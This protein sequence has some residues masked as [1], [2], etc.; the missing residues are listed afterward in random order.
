MGLDENMRSVFLL[1]VDISDRIKKKNRFVSNC[2]AKFQRNKKFFACPFSLFF[3]PNDEEKVL[4]ERKPRFSQREKKRN[5]FER[6]TRISN[7]NGL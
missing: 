2:K 1:G 5:D 7:F 3:W 6:F 4:K